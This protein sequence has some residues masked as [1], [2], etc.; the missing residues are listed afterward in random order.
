MS[1]PDKD[2]YSTKSVRSYK[3]EAKHIG[4]GRYSYFIFIYI[5]YNIVY[6]N[7]YIYICNNYLGPGSYSP[8]S[9]FGGLGGYSPLIKKKFTMGGKYKAERAEGPTATRFNPDHGLV[10]VR[11]PSFGFGGSPRFDTFNTKRNANRS[12]GPNI[13]PKSKDDISYSKGKSIGPGFS[14]Q[15]NP[16]D[17]FP[18]TKK[19]IDG[20]I[21]IYISIYI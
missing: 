15:T 3:E 19:P 5:V 1:Y 13:L 17:R 14:R 7:I 4:L 11:S 10:K 9:D 2:Y 12:P 20:N 16:P 6:I 8:P 18:K 21:F